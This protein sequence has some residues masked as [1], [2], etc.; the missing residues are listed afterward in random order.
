M[1]EIVK[2]KYSQVFYDEKRDVYIK[3]FTPKLKKKIKYFFRLRKY[4]GK[5]CKY[6]SDLFNSLG[7]KTPKIEEYDKYYLVTKNVSGKMLNKVLEEEKDKEKI[8]EYLEKYIKIV[9]KIIKNKIYYADFH[10]G[11]FI[12]YNEELYII[13][14]ED[15]KKDIF[16]IFRKK[17][18][19][20]QLENKL[21][22]IIDIE[23]EKKGIRAKKIYKRI[24]AEV[25]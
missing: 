5:N 10:F 17:K 20:S 19:L 13:D 11:N 21:N 23:M 18:M 3:K 9:S 16:F 1:K 25:K 4:P 7:I 24:E 22:D 14:L 8:K 6:I 2:N 15:Y 12:V